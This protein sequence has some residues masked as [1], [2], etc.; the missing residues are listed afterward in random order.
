[1]RTFPDIAALKHAATANDVELGVSDW[2][3]IDQSM[4]D[5][6]ADATGDHQWIHVDVERAKASPFGTTIAHGW[7][8]LSLLARL[9]NE[10]YRIEQLAARLNYGANKVRF[11]APVPAGSRIRAQFRIVAV[12]EVAQGTRLTTQATVE[13]DGSD[14]P[15]CVAELVGILIGDVRDSKL[16]GE[17]VSR[18]PL[19]GKRHRRSGLLPKVRICQPC[20]PRQGLLTERWPPYR[21]WP[22]NP[23]A[24]KSY[25]PGQADNIG[26]G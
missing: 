8:T 6:F 19:G 4:I 15:I 9:S 16:R 25:R 1:M 26:K 12:E 17:G 21:C 3:T 22:R 13:R 24:R 10:T 11:T 20:V 18:L 23:A 7:L 2:V 5:R 14:K